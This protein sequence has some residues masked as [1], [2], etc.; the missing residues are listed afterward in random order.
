MTLQRATTQIGLIDSIGVAMRFWLG[1][2]WR[3]A[4]RFTVERLKA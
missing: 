1:G 4:P 3:I 2:A